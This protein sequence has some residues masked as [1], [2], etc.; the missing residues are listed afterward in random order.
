MRD[1]P[2]PKRQK[3]IRGAAFIMGPAQPVV[4]RAA[5]THLHHLPLDQLHDF[6]ASAA[7]EIKRLQSHVKQTQ[8]MIDDLKLVQP[9]IDRLEAQR[10]P[11]HDGARSHAEVAAAVLAAVGHPMQLQDLLAAMAARGAVIAGKT[12]RIQKSN[13]II[14]LGRSPL[15]RRVRRGVYAL[16]ESRASA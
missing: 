9:L 1:K 8:A 3:R 13:L 5:L 16:S 15:V 7:S 2:R 10:T 11:V 4:R 12:P 14:T 6:A